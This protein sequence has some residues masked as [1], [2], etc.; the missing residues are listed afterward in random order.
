[1]ALR[2]D[3]C[4]T[5]AKSGNGG[6]TQRTSC[7]SQQKAHM[8][9]FAVS[10]PDV[11]ALMSPPAEQSHGDGYFTHH[12]FWSPGVRLFRSLHFKSKALIISSAFLVPIVLL[13]ITLWNSTQ[14]IVDFAN[15]ERAGVVAM[16]AIVPAYQNVLEVRNA[17]RAKLG[18]FDSAA[19]Y[20]KAREKTDASLAALRA[21]V[22]S[23]SDP[24]ALAPAVTKLEAAWQA[25]A[26]SSNGADS[27]GSTVFGPVS[28]ALIELLV[29]VGDDSNLV[30][31]PDVDSFYLINAMVL[32]M[33][34]AAEEVGQV[35]G[36]GTYSLAK[37]GLDDKNGKRLHAWQTNAQTKL[38]ETR[39]Y[40]GRAV[41]ANA[42]LKAKL[43]FGPI[44][45]ASNFAKGAAAALEPGKSDAAKFYA[46]GQAA[47]TG[48]F[49][50][51]ASGLNEL[52]D[53]LRARTEAAQKARNLRFA[54][55]IGCLVVA[56]YLFY[57]FFL[58]SHG[59]LNH[60]KSHLSRMTQGD[61][62][63]TPTPWGSDEAAELMSSLQSMQASLLNIVSR[64]RT[65]SETIVHASA[66]IATASHDLSGRTVQTSASLE[67][68]ASSME[69]ISSTVKQTADSVREAAA[70][71]SSNAQTAS[72][73]GAVIAEVVSTMQGINASSKKIADIIG[74]IDGI[75]FQTNILALNAAVEAAR[76][77]EQGRG[78]AVVAAE[79]RS[80]AQRSAQAAREIK[81]LI[82]ASV[83]R[84]ESGAKIVKGAG[85]TMNELV[86]NAQRINSLL[87][88]ISTAANE[89]SSGVAQV[90]SAL[91]DLDQMTQQNSTLVDQTATAASALKGQAQ[92]LALEV[93]K[94]KLPALRVA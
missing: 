2:A 88:E 77:G 32:T 60:V 74:T 29:K 1:M 70:V 65:S 20:R 43:D 85:D 81:T 17:T 27:N 55:V 66:N 76:A 59:G 10:P 8:N 5:T 3:N 9:S 38:T 87:S 11:P 75:A 49:K 41:V 54:V 52:D 15:K 61:L 45:A 62:T 48:L 93:A 71:A 84:V 16:R 80:L 31:D 79:V 26:S 56:C 91:N 86:A 4:T 18:G 14:D 24:L 72:R 51:Y 25:T 63:N 68:S 78:F 6:D 36:W 47:A 22:T 69:E 28:S 92:E 23:S 7:R 57:C 21:Y 39:T 58:V 34:S 50:L 12:G 89:Q 73:G 30:L 64:V 42:A 35:W 94:F 53:L 46:D 82:T 37:G 13:A 33:P 67:E 40:F 83:D 90:G 44:E 19:D